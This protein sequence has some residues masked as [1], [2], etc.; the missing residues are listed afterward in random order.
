MIA[1]LL[2][3]G[4]GLLIDTSSNIETLRLKNS[5]ELEIYEINC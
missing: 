3:E 4:L 2:L 1:K 5:D